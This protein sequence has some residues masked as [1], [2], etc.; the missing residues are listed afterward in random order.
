M[1]AAHP[2]RAGTGPRRPLG[3]DRLHP[4]ARLFA[5][6]LAAVFP[7]VGGSVTDAAEAR[8]ILA[9]APRTPG[10]PPPVGAVADRTVPGPP[11]A[12]P[13]PVR[14]YRPDP[15]RWPGP[16]P[17]VVYC[18]GGGFVLC[19]LDTH[20][21]TVRHLVRASGSVAVSVD[22]RRAPEHPFP[23]A[24]EDTYAV[25]RWAAAHAGGLGGDPGALVL[26]GD[27]SGGN[28][29]AAAALLAVRRGGPRAALQALVY[30]A[31]SAAA[32][33]ASYRLYAEGYYL[34]AA[35]M[36]WFWRQYLGPS[37]DG[38]DPLASPPNAAREELALLPPAHVVVAGC[39]PLHDEGRAYHLLLRACG[40]P[41][42]LDAHPD[43][44][45]GFLAA[46]RALPQ[47]RAALARLGGAIASTVSDGKN[48]GGPGGVAG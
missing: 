6:G 22:Y 45:H 33:S 3:E 38:A 29:A 12:A 26:A 36:R 11:G 15:A 13:V 31:L 37:G 10:E 17:T 18:H 4:A 1:T 30:P 14:I 9:A 2:E 8:R 27:S 42:T 41:S 35:H 43:V 24:V 16:R 47:A 19:D 44:P 20:D 40:V 21:T 5:D 32:D 39:D 25:L 7:D 48:S 34:T 23:A 46:S 28:L